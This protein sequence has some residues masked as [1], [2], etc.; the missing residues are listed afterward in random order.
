MKC[1]LCFGEMEEFKIKD[2]EYILYRCLDCDFM[3]FD[4]KYAPELYKR[5][6]NRIT[7]KPSKTN[8]ANAIKFQ[9]Y[10]EDKN[11]LDIGSGVARCQQG[12]DR[13][14]VKYKSYTNVDTAFI[15]ELAKKIGYTILDIDVSSSRFPNKIPKINYDTIIVSHVLEH[16]PHPKKVLNI[17]KSI[18]NENSVIYI[19]IPTYD[20]VNINET[21]DWF[22]YEHLSYFRIKNFLKLMNEFFTEIEHGM[23]KNNIFYIGKI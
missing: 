13:V 6:S 22:V 11:I 12:M 18:L 16:M 21:D 4:Y 5:I 8:I 10:Y 9:R 15:R 7:Q 20:N 1:E 19:E 14:N 3:Q 2:N 23:D 17:W